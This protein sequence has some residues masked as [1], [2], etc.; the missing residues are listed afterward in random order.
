WRVCDSL[1]NCSAE[2]TATVSFIGPL[3]F[4]SDASAVTS[5]GLYTLD[6]PGKSIPSGFTTNAAPPAT[7]IIRSGTYSMGTTGATKQLAIRAGDVVLGQGLAG[8]SLTTLGITQ[9]AL[10]VGTLPTLP[11]LSTGT[12]PTLHMPDPTDTSGGGIVIT[13]SPFFKGYGGGTVKYLRFTRAAERTASWILFSNSSWTSTPGDYV[14]DQIVS[15]NGQGFA[16]PQV[17]S[18]ITVTNSN[19]TISEGFGMNGGTI[20]VT[21][22]PIQLTSTDTSNSSILFSDFDSSTVG[23]ITATIDASSPITI[24]NNVGHLFPLTIS[25]PAWMPNGTFTINS[26]IAITRTST[27]VGLYIKTM[28]NVA[29]NGKVTVTTATGRPVQLDAV[30]NLT[31]PNAANTAKMTATPASALNGGITMSNVTV[32]AAGLTLTNIDVRK[33]YLSFDNTNGAPSGPI[34]ITGGTVVGDF[35]NPC[36]WTNLATNVTVTGVTTS[37]CGF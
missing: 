7:Y 20:T 6:V 24:A 18:S 27:T 15:V 12:I 3:I 21:N 2:R 35:I 33:G 10:S 13:Q 23:T 19:L 17:G 31:M 16:I 36:I 8:L 22:T 32:G 5:P 26:D 30:T 28:S 11:D 25:N 4:F 37:N 1:G 29:L 34:T 14:F 9:A